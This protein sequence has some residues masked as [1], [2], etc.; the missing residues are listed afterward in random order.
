[1]II[2]TILFMIYITSVL[3]YIF[4]LVSELSECYISGPKEWAIVI[5][6]LIGGFI[7]IFNT[8]MLLRAFDNN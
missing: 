3:L 4:I 6:Y 8:I 7:P 1:M 5:F 2:V